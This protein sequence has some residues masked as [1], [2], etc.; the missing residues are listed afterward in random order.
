MTTKSWFDMAPWIAIAITLILSIIIPFLTQITNNRFQLRIKRMEEKN[1]LYTTKVNAFIDFV[2][3]VGAC[4]AC[5]D[6]SSMQLA[7]SSIQNMF[8]FMP[9]ENWADLDLLYSCLRKCEWDKAEMLL[10]SLSKEA[11]KILDQS[12]SKM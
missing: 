5:S 9:E 7:G 4:I 6:A 8:L 10:N 1:N 12:L 2:K 3:N 11:S